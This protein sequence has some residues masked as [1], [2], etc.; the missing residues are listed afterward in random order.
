MVTLK[1]RS[2]IARRLDYQARHVEDIR[3]MKFIK[4]N[5]FK[6]HAKY[7]EIRILKLSI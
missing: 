5:A 4:M 2:L 3:N 7:V 1:I 6:F